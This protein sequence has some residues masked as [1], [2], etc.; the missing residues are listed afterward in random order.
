MS[1]LS[2]VKTE[3]R[4]LSVLRKAL[5]RL[6][7]NHQLIADSEKAIEKIVI[8]QDKSNIEFV[9]N[10]KTYELHSDLNFWQ[11]RWPVDEFLK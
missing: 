5:V 3:L 9:W 6:K 11:Q 2:K 7:F 10:G 4:D 1:H 8:F